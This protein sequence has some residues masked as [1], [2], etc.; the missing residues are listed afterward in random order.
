MINGPIVDHLIIFKK[1]LAITIDFL[2]DKL[3][4]MRRR[5]MSYKYFKFKT[6]VPQNVGP[7]ICLSNLKN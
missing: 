2:N 5:I 3:L 6:G 1:L 7:L 4:F